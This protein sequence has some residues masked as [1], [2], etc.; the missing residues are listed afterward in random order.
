[1]RWSVLVLL[2]ASAI[3]FG[4]IT[5]TQLQSQ[6][7]PSGVAGCVYNVTPPTLANRQTVVLQCDINGKLI[8]Q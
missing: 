2:A 8:L 6:P 4:A 5:V 3:I 1:M 7:A